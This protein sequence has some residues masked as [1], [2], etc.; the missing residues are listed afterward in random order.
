[1]LKKPVIIAGGAAVVLIALAYFVVLPM[2]KS[3]PA[4]SAAAT[5]TVDAPADAGATPTAKK[6]RRTSEPGLMYPL[7]ERVLNLTPTGGMP[8]FARIELALEFAPDTPNGAKPKP[9][10]AAAKAGSATPLDPALEPVTKY[11][12]Q[13]DDALVR[14]IGSKTMEAM[15]SADGKAALKQEILDTVSTIVP[16]PDL[17]GVYIVQLVVQ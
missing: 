1:M 5:A 13:I 11:K 6:H 15:T 9:A 14:I 8:H 12:A 3:K 2:L 7:P 16:K 10:A 4:A 17:I